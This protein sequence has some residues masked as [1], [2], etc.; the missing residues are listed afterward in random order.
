MKYI[1]YA[2][3]SSE[4]EDRQVLSIDSQVSE[5]QK[6]AV[7]EGIVIERTFQESMSAKAPGRP[8]FE[9]MLSYI[10]SQ[11]GGCGVVVWKLDRLA[12]N[13]LDGGKIS[14][15]MDRE[16]IKEIRT[17]EKLIKNI[18]DDK[19]F[20]SLDFGIA[21]KYV[22]DLSV[23]V[24]RG[25]RA[26]LEKGG[27]PSTAPIGY[28]NDKADKTIIVNE[29][30]RSF[31]VRTFEMYISSGKSTKEIADILYKE[32]FRTER[33]CKYG[34]S[35][36]YKILVNP[37]YYGIM[38]KDGKY[39]PGNHKPIISQ[40]IFEEAQAVLTR[41]TH[42]KPKTHFF[43]FRGLLTCHVCG[44]LLT[45]S[46]KKGHDYYY[47]TNGRGNCIQHL[48]YMREKLLDEIIAPVLDDLKLDEELIE[49]AYLAKKE[50]EQIEKCYKETTREQL[51]SQLEVVR[52]RQSKLLDVLLD[53]HITE[54]MYQEKLKTLNK[55]E[56]SIKVE[57]KNFDLKSEK[58]IVTLEQI[59]ETLLRACKAKEEFIGGGAE[60]KH[61]F[62]QE[63][64]WNLTIEDKKIASVS[65][66][67]P[68]LAISKVPQNCT[69]EQM[70]G[71]KG[72]NLRM[73]AS[74]APALPLGYS[75]MTVN[76]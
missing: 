27:W 57:L 18:A 36:I 19:F 44:C 59:K 58:S 13:A 48:K 17:Y 65:Y 28:L 11:K 21:K 7:R 16:L 24:R 72:S 70:L 14:W 73:E 51:G 74:K 23:N 3:K 63:L 29:K 39:Y 54:E 12:R 46:K 32:G 2:R 30:L 69:F 15:Y 10:E 66:N 71:R 40:K 60:E 8:V 76:N 41:R 9:E 68:Y 49:I 6:L 43:R 25:N 75:P 47:C 61:N 35:K 4:S 53:S 20:M 5:L 38:E 34:K 52:Q 67:M 45:A 50:K 55:E 22:D 31:I 42:K 64:L 33:G 56:A 1:I 26:K 37:F 62:L